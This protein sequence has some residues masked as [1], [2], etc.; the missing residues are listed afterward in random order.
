MTQSW[1]PLSQMKNQGHEKYKEIMANFHKVEI[2]FPHYS[3]V[4]Q[5]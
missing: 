5:C 2:I 3:K 4:G 1:I